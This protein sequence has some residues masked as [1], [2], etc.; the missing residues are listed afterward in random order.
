[1]SNSAFR[2]QKIA[3][4]APIIYG[5]TGVTSFSAHWVLL[6]QGNSNVI[7]ISAGTVGQGLK[8]LS[9]S[10]IPIMLDKVQVD[11]LEYIFLPGVS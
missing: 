11:K 9:A 1:M 3:S 2:R 4:P 6:G 5:G 7:A 8:T 10:N